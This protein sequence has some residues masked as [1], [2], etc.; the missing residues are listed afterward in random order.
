M[1]IVEKH[2]PETADPVD[3]PAVEAAG[4]D[5]GVPYP[6][7]L[8]VE[9]PYRPGIKRVK[10]DRWFKQEYHDREVERIWKKTWQMVCREEIAEVGDYVIYD[11]ATLSFI[12]MRTAPDTIQAYWNSCPHRARKIR[13]Y[14]GRGVSELRCM[15]HGWS[16]NLDGSVKAIPCQWDFPGVDQEA[17]LVQA[18]AGTWGGWVF[19]NPDTEAEPLADYLGELPNHFEGANHDMR[20]RWKQVHVATIIDANWKVVQE[21]FIEAWHV[22]TTHPQLVFGG[23]RGGSNTR[24]DDFGN[25]MRSAPALPTDAQEGKPNWMLMTDDDQ[26]AVDSYYDR[27]LDEEPAIVAHAG[28]SCNQVII[29]NAREFYRKIIGDKVDEYHDV[30]FT[31]GGM[32]SVFPNF[33]PWSEFSRIIYRFR[34]YQNDPN[35]AIMDVMLLAPWP[36]DRPRP[37]PAKVHWLQAGED[38]TASPELGQL[39]RIFL[40]DVANMPRVQEGLKTSGRGYVILAEHNEAPMR[41]LHDMYEHWMGLEEG[42]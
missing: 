1:D 6:E 21:A 20:E 19:I 35:R 15:F 25:W 42:E 38:T 11:I 23:E 24:W 5:R 14:E 17:T 22:T 13:E 26:A 30:E 33:H 2:G 37:A 16:W 36:E 9:R 34:P 27:H 28:Q 32:V 8:T 29:D 10:V 18:K 3:G 39:A 40:Q 7:H 12:V 4:V 31:G 41:K